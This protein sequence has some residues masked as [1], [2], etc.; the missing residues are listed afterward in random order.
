MLEKLI[1]YAVLAAPGMVFV[2]AFFGVDRFLAVTAVVVVVLCGGSLSYSMGMHGVSAFGMSM[3]QMGLV[4][5]AGVVG[6]PIARA[7]EER[8]GHLR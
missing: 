1:S 5:V 8:D 3:L 7:R 6:L 2:A 4:F